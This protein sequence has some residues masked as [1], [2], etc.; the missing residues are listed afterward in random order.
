MCNRLI[1][2]YRRALRSGDGEANPP[3]SDGRRLKQLGKG[4]PVKHGTSAELRQYREATAE[5]TARGSKLPRKAAKLQ[6]RAARTANRHRWT[7]RVSKGARVSH[8]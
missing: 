8:G 6:V 5:R 7:R 3:P 2:R 4:V 1:F